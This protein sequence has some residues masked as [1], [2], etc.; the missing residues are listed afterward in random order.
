VAQQRWSI[1]LD[2]DLRFKIQAS[3]EAEIL[4]GGTGIT[5]DTA[6]LTSAIRVNAIRKPDVRTDVGRKD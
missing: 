2:E 4:M 6:V 3:R 1:V 5:I